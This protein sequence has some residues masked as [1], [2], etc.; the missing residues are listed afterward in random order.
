M[1]VQMAVGLWCDVIVIIV[2]HLQTKA[3]RRQEKTRADQHSYDSRSQGPV[4]LFRTK[5]NEQKSIGKTRQVML[6]MTCHFLQSLPF[7]MV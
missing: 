4:A 6:A 7:A 2:Y 1:S 5:T 3:S